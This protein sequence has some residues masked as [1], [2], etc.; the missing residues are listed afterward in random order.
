M[1]PPKP[2]PGTEPTNVQRRLLRVIV[3][4]DGMTLDEVADAAEADGLPTS[5][6]AKGPT[7]CNYPLKSVLR[8]MR[9]AGWLIYNRHTDPPTWTRTP[10]GTSL[11]D[12]P[13]PTA[14]MTTTPRQEATR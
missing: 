9:R 3:K 10:T 6:G 1:T 12:Q 4:A 7:V 5:I 14:R 2:A 11:A 8:H 13:T